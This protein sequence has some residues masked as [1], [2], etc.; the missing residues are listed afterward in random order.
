VKLDHI[1]VAGETL[2]EA[3]EAVETALGVALQPGGVHR[4]FGTHN[5]LLGLSDG[6]YLEAI[7]V[8]PKV[9]PERRPRWFDLDRFSGAARLTNWICRT[10]DL[11][12]LLEAISVDAGDPVALQRGDLRWLMAVPG[13][14]VLPF[15]N[16]FPALIEWRSDHPASR[17]EQSGCALRRLV[18]SHPNAVDLSAMLMQHLDTSKVVFENGP[19]GLMAEFITP[20]G[21]RVL[22]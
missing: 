20:H 6:L 7:S 11:A 8:N 9:A 19:V 21:L 3:T 13:D 5:R 18:V 10:E 1:A 4:T 2:D 22:H 14:G 17:L 15:D 16:M 12:A